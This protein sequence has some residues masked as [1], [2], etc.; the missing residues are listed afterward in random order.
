M[1]KKIYIVGNMNVGFKKKSDAIAIRKKIPY[2]V[3]IRTKI[4]K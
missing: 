4:I 2:P 1:A 3:K